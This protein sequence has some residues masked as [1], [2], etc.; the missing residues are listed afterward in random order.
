LVTRELFGLTRS[1]KINADDRENK[2]KVINDAS[3]MSKTSQLVIKQK[4]LDL[5]NGKCV[6]KGGKWQN[7]ERSEVEEAR[8]RNE[9]TA[10]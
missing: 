4:Q 3:E 10:N 5:I 9:R 6:V 8:N 1:N 2:V 7:E